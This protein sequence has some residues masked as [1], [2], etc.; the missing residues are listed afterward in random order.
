MRLLLLLDDND[1]KKASELEEE[2]L[3]DPLV[4]AGG[5]GATTCFE[6]R[7]KK[8][9]WATE[10]TVRQKVRSAEGTVLSECCCC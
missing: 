1:L 9:R 6:E 5:A 7:A 2:Q 8:A 10:S 4:D 3:K